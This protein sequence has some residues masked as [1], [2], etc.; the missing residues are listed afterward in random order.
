MAKTVGGIRGA[1]F[2]A[3]AKRWAS[4]IAN[5]AMRKQAEESAAIMSSKL[6]I[7]VSDLPPVVEVKIKSGKMGYTLARYNEGADR[8]EINADRNAVQKGLHYKESAVSS[9]WSSQSNTV[10]H[11]LSHRIHE[12]LNAELIRTPQGY[13]QSLEIGRLKSDVIKNNVSQY[14]ATNVKE[15]H[16]ELISGILRGKKYSKQI[17]DDSILS[18]SDNRVAKRLYKLGLKKGD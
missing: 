2:N 16:A 4:G 6:G 5:P 9:G 15:F 3:A 10:L 18:K 17:L 1:G 12:R 11:E 14:G 7:P 8:I 13:R